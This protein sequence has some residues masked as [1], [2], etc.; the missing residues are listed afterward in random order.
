ME[1]SKMAKASFSVRGFNLCE[2]ILRHSPEQLRR[3]IRRMKTLNMNSLIVHYDYGWRRYHDLISEE[4]KNAGI[5]ITLMTFGPRTF[6]SLVD[7]KKEWFAKDE[8]GV[9]FCNFSECETLPCAANPEALEGFR[10]GAKIFLRRLPPNIK[11]IHMRAGDGVYYCRCKKCALKP[12]RE[13]WTPFVK[14]FVEAVIETDPKLQMETDIY[15]KRYELPSDL[16][17]Y[18]EMPRLMYDT[19]GRN[20]LFPIGAEEASTPDDFNATKSLQDKKGSADR[21]PNAYHEERLKQWSG[22]MPR[23]IYI[24]E[25]AM[26][27]RYRG[28]FQQNTPAL[29]QDLLVYKKL[30][31]KGV[32]YEAYEPGY[33]FFEK[34]FEALSNALTEIETIQEYAP[35]ALEEKIL[36][37]RHGMSLFCIDRNFPLD[38]FISDPLELKM[39]Q[40]YRQSLWELTPELVSRYISLA[41][42]HKDILD[43]LWIGFNLL[44]SGKHTKSLVFDSLNEEENA[45]LNYRKL[46]DFMENIPLAD[47]PVKNTERMIFNIQDK[48]LSTRKGK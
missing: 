7:W 12:Y 42:E 41:F 37:A 16:M 35:S 3:F 34:S 38:K 23:K 25:N 13:Q 19:F 21:S 11:R 2:S 43:A 5:E 8:N 48:I 39:A 47:D 30:G 18:R 6:Y 1:F 45:F 26:M 24:H 27:H 9:P 10:A 17:P 46:W 44:T 33:P 32:C 22:L 31:V 4:C 40:L 14:A 20:P 36:S 29:L 15:F 28:V